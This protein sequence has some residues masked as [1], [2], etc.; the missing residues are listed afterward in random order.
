MDAQSVD[1]PGSFLADPNSL[2]PLARPPGKEQLFVF[3]FT[4]GSS[5][6]LAFSQPHQVPTDLGPTLHSAPP[7]PSYFIC[8]KS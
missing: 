5:Y 4:Q 8:P 7:P 6:L 3:I 2:H 1:M